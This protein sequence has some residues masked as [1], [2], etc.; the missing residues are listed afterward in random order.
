ME[1]KIRVLFDTQRLP[2]SAFEIFSSADIQK[3]IKANDYTARE[4][5]AFVEKNGPQQQERSKFIDGIHFIEHDK[6]DPRDLYFSTNS[7]DKTKT[8][9]QVLR[10]YDFKNFAPKSKKEV[11]NLLNNTDIG[12]W[13]ECPSFLYWGAQ[14][15]AHRLGYGLV[16]ESRAPKEPNKEKKDKFYVCKH[17][18]ALL[19][20]MPFWWPQIRK[21]FLEYYKDEIEKAEQEQVK[22]ETKKESESE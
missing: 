20:H 22:Q 4:L 17:G 2:D 15:K 1:R 18:Q 5:R 10:F 14:Y 9:H 12:I 13:C 8:Y 11:I 3:S 19:R 21:A 6:T 7:Q 16:P